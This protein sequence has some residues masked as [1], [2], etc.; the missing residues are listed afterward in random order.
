[1]IIAVNSDQ[2]SS[3]LVGVKHFFHHA[4]NHEQPTAEPVAMNQLPDL[5]RASGMACKSLFHS[6]MIHLERISEGTQ[7]EL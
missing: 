1:V 5:T 2:A 4:A 3:I 7:Q 6:D